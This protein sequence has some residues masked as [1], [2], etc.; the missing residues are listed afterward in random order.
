[1]LP[2]YLIYSIIFTPIIFW[3]YQ[4]TQS[5]DAIAFFTSVTLF[6]YKYN[7]TGFYP[8]LF[9]LLC[10]DKGSYIGVSLCSRFSHICSSISFLSCTI[11][12]FF[13]TWFF[14][15]AFKHIL[16]SPFYTY[17]LSIPPHPSSLL[18]PFFA[19]LHRNIYSQLSLFAVSISSPSILISI[20]SN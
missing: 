19:L 20:Y 10:Y 3:P 14:P 8:H 4:H 6:I 17:L 18:I 11:S 12:F 16:V 5:L 1:M 9:C 13:S 2:I 7:S 15:S